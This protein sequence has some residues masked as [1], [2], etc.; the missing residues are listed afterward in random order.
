M[1]REAF[2]RAVGGCILAV[3]FALGGVPAWAQPIVVDHTCTD[4]AAIPASVIEQVRTGRKVHYAHT[5]HGSQIN[6]GMELIENATYSVEFGYRELPSAPGVLC[7]FDGQEGDDYV[8]PDLYWQTAQGLQNTRNVLNHNPSLTNS[9]W[10]WCT[11]LDYYSA[12][13]VQ[14]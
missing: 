6:I 13:E 3:Y 14:Q 9:M 10:G 4:L 11:Q 7:V 1:G 2:A 12:A 5:S 8:T